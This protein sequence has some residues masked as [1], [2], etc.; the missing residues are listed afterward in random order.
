MTIEVS[1]HDDSLGIEMKG[2][3]TFMDHHLME[4]KEFGTFFTYQVNGYWHRSSNNK[5][6]KQVKELYDYNLSE[7]GY[8][9]IEEDF[10]INNNG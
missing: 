9:E 10:D 2:T 1:T 3:H 8:I 7:N 5:M 6:L 4:Y